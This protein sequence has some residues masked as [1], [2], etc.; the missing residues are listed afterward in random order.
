MMKFYVSYRH[1]K[2][3]DLYY[4]SGIDAHGNPACGSDHASSV[5]TLKYRLFKNGITGTQI[6]KQSRHFLSIRQWMNSKDALF[7]L[8]QLAAILNTGINL[9]NAINIFKS[10]QND[11]KMTRLYEDI[12]RRLKM[13]GG[14]SET[15]ENY[16]VL[17]DNVTLHIIHSGEKSGHTDRAIQQAGSYLEQK[18]KT[19]GELLTALLYP[20]ILCLVT[21]A[22]LGLMVIFVIPQFQAL[23]TDTGNQL[24][25]L[26]RA[27]LCSGEFIKSNVLALAGGVAMIITCQKL[28]NRLKGFEI[29]RTIPVLDRTRKQAHTLRLC[30]ILNNL[31]SAGLPI[32]EALDLC[33][34]ISGS[35]Q[36]QLA[37]SQTIEK[38]KRGDRLAQA[39]H[40]TAYFETLFIQLVKTG[41]Q[42]DS[43]S[44]MLEH[45]ANFYQKRL[46]DNLSRLKIILEPLLIVVL[47]VI[48]GIILIAMYLPVFSIGSSF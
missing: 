20:M 41:E 23:Y 12:H 44:V 33:K 10:G 2:K 42:S 24:P 9:N 43:L 29:I 39:L 38:I 25:R 16:P 13:G 6:V 45:C 48:I 30:R 21:L 40:E 31:Y 19:S 17:F 28:L 3:R 4:W 11:K 8:Y 27:V 35:R 34:N 18:I 14:L 36:Y 5:L 47:G 26:T 32:T 46:A 22:V 15:L 7:F 1:Y 37:I